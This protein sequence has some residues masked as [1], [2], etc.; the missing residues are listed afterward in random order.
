MKEFRVQ[1]GSS[2]F[3]DKTGDHSHKAE[4]KLI[5]VCGGLDYKHGAQKDHRKRLRRN[6]FTS[7]VAFL[8]KKI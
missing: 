8:K 7:K 1:T 6:V 3:T 2:G 4:L 5:R